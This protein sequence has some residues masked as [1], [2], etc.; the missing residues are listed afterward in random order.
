M[1]TRKRT[2]NVLPVATTEWE[3]HLSRS[4]G[5]STSRG[6]RDLTDFVCRIVERATI[7]P[8]YH[9]SPPLHRSRS[10]VGR[11][12]VGRTSSSNRRGRSRTPPRGRVGRRTSPKRMILWNSAP[13]ISPVRSPSPARVVR[14]ITPVRRAPRRKSGSR[15]KSPATAAKRISPTKE[16]QPTPREKVSPEKEKQ[17]AWRE[18]VS[19]EKQLN[20]RRFTAGTNTTTGSGAGP[21]TP[22]VQKKSTPRA[23]IRPSRDKALRDSIKANRDECKRLAKELQESVDRRESAQAAKTEKPK[24]KL[25]KS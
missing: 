7:R 24:K 21:S 22:Q 14:E 1:G 25:P 4:L 13:L 2:Y 18:R 23:I 8:Q 10:A 16:K 12:A 19:P 11:S 20:T 5:D 6:F 3:L 15:P 17:P 9:R